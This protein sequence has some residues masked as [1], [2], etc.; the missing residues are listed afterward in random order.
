[1]LGIRVDVS[2]EHHGVSD[3]VEKII[4]DFL[5]VQLTVEDVIFWQVWWIGWRIIFSKSI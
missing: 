3:S 5:T 4:K 1:M 2:D